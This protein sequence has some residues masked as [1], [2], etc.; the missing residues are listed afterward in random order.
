MTPSIISKERTGMDRTEILAAVKELKTGEIISLMHE[1]CDYLN[2]TRRQDV[3]DI[4][5]TAQ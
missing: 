4:T 3:P 5:D 1:I 2:M